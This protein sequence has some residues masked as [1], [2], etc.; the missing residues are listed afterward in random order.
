[1][2]SNTGE[3]VLE[4]GEG[5]DSDALTGS[6]EAPQHRRRH[7]ALV[8]AKEQPLVAAYRHA[9]DRAL[10]GIIVDLQT[11]VLT[12]AGQRCPVLQRVAHRPPLLGSSAKL[13]PGSPISSQTPPR[14]GWLDELDRLKGGWL[15]F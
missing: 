1:M 5:I 7:A 6:H 12:V 10:G 8:A 2:I 15:W 3:D 13:L 9:A 14:S 11:S 4:P